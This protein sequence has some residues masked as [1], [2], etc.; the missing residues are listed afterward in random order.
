MIILVETKTPLWVVASSGPSGRIQQLSQPP[1]PTATCAQRVALL[2]ALQPQSQN[3]A[4][5]TSSLGSGKYTE[6]HSSDRA[7]S[8]S[9]QRLESG[10]SV[11]RSHQA[12]GGVSA[13]SVDHVDL[14]CRAPWTGCGRG[15]AANRKPLLDNRPMG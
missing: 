13:W 14:A 3:Q 6:R 9:L 5:H 4:R 11:V 8:T 15:L 10:E 12:Q 7:L 1:N 2:L